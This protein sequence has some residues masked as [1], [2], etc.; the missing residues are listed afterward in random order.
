MPIEALAK[1]GKDAARYGPMRPVGLT[2]PATGKRPYAVVQL[3]KENLQ[4]SAYNLVGFQTNLK[5]PEQKRVFSMIPGLEDAEFLRYGVMHRKSFLCSPKLV[6]E[7]YQVRSRP[8]LYFA[9]QITGVEGYIESAASGIVAGLNLARQLQGKPP[10]ILPQTTMLGA[11]AAYISNPENARQFQPMGCNMG[12]L[13]SLPYRVKEKEKR[14]EQVA[15]LALQA[16]CERAKEQ[17]VQIYE[18]YC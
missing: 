14:Y 18:D 12:L 1:R 16:L 3:R 4:G 15:R 8:M 10:F 7:T 5:F 11:L 6:D 17:E 9:G 2:D 13:P